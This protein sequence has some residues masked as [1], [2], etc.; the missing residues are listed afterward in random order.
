MGTLIHYFSLDEI[1]NKYEHKN[2][3]IG[4]ASGYIFADTVDGNTRDFLKKASDEIKRCAVAKVETTKYV[5]DHI[6]EEWRKIVERKTRPDPYSLNKPKKL[7]AEDK[8]KFIKKCEREYKKAVENLQIDSTPIMNRKIINMYNSTLDEECNE[9]GTPCLIVLLEG[10]TSGKYWMISE[11]RKD[12]EKDKI[13][14]ETDL[15]EEDPE[16][17]NVIYPAFASVQACTN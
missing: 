8:E 15:D 12:K 2:V 6:E 1:L 3:K 13:I 5:K 16:R 14:T 9:D 17:D 4:C 11:S 10:S 7:T